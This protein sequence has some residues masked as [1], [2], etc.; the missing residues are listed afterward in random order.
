MGNHS[1][2]GHPS[3]SGKVSDDSGRTEAGMSLHD[4]FHLFTGNSLI[5]STS[6]TVTHCTVFCL[7]ASTKIAELML[8]F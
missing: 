3:G 4:P 8:Y 2:S 5:F 1:Y 7:I 6:V